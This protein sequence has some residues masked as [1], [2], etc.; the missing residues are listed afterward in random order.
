LYFIR[1]SFHAKTK[2]EDIE[3][4]AVFLSIAFF[5]CSKENKE[6][7]IRGRI[8]GFNNEKVVYTT[9]IAGTWFYGDKKSIAP[10]SSGSFQIKMKI[11][12]PSFETI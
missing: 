4:N 10:D 3:H 12:E 8:S 6:I 11:D 9:S 2:N 7:T 1:L 5:G